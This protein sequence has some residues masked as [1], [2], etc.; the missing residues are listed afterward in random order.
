MKLFAFCFWSSFLDCITFI[1][2][3][4]LSKKR[5]NDSAGKTPVPA[6][7][8][9]AAASP[10]SGNLLVNFSTYN[11]QYTCFSNGDHQFL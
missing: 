5:A 4:E 6:K 8:P 9:K 10:K 7:K 1:L 11:L 3:P 2:K